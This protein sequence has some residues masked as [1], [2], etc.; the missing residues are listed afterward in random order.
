MNDRPIPSRRERRD[1]SRNL[2]R[3]LQAAHD[4]FTERG[5]EVTMEEVARQA[6]VG[7]GTIYRRFPSKEHLL[8]AVGQEVRVQVQRGLQTAIA[9]QPDPIGKFRALISTLYQYGEKYALLFELHARLDPAQRAYDNHENKEQVYAAIHTLLT[10]ILV[11]GQQQGVFRAD[12]PAVLATFCLE[13]INPHAFVNFKRVIGGS[14]ERIA[15]QVLPLMLAAIAAQPV[16][17]GRD[18]A[19]HGE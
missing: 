15:A 11:E 10:S 2:E 6:G 13:L 17:H 8:T 16:A 14:A 1:T 12:D 4:L 19:P 7:V 3:V 9:V 18:E 5:P